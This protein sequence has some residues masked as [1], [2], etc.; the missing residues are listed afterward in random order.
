MLFHRLGLGFSP[1]TSNRE[2]RHCYVRAA[3]LERLLE[4]PGAL[5]LLAEELG[6]APAASTLSLAEQLEAIRSRAIHLS[7]TQS[8]LRGLSIE[9]I[10]VLT[11][12]ASSRF[13]RTELK[14]E[15]T[16]QPSPQEL[17]HACTRWLDQRSSV[18]RD[19]H[20]LGRS[21]WPMVGSS[22]LGEGPLGQFTV[23]L[24]PMFDPAMLDAQ[25]ESVGAE[26]N[27]AHEHY[28]ACSPATALGYLDQQAHL[29]HPAR[30]DSLVL[31]RKLRTFGIGLLLV[32][33]EGVFLYLPAR[34]QSHPPQAL[35]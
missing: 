31:E 1:A 8:P 32:E 29:T 7:V 22:S 17:R 19:G 12:Y 26:A 24:V 27:F 6:V 14:R 2:L 5:G 35:R 21:R 23:A 34:Y 33:R 25:L 20:R 9:E 15:L 30:W 4:T 16:R 3:A 10:L 13:D 28:L 11:V 18:T